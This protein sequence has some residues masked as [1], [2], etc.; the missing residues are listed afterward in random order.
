MKQ[1][2]FELLERYV[3]DRM[4]PAERREFEHRLGNES[5]LKDAYQDCQDQIIAIGYA[6]LEEKLKSYRLPVEKTTHE[7]PEFTSDRKPLSLLRRSGLMKW[8]AAAAVVIITALWFLLNGPGIWSE[9]DFDEIFYQD[10]GLPTPMSGTGQYR[11]Y[12]AMVDYKAGKYETALDKWEGVGGIGLDT[13]TY[14]RGMAYMGLGKSDE[15]LSLLES[16]AATSPLGEKTQW[17]RIYLLIQTNQYAQALAL[18]STVPDTFEG[19]DKVLE[20]L[21]SKQ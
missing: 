10:P 11:F 7:H 14:Y 17:Y 9:P 5:E 20:Y 15:A 8:I 12:D 18:I 13:L 16:V 1:K 4:G 21:K 3:L 2:D 19:Y 6:G